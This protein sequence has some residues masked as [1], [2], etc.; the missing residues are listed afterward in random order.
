LRDLLLA[1]VL[2]VL[3]PMCFRRP[4]IGAMT[5]AW[6]SLMSPHR[7]AYGF[8][9]TAPVAMLVGGATLLGLL[10]SK[11]PKRLPMAAPVVWLALFTGWMLVTYPFSFEPMSVNYEQLDKVMKIMLMTFVVVAVIHTRKQVDI[12][13]AVVALSVGFYGIKGGVFA[14][15]T[16]G[17]FRVR[18]PV[19]FIAGNN[20]IG[21]ALVMTI[22]LLYYLLLQVQNANI[23]RVLWVSIFLTAVAAI[24]TQSR[25]ALLAILGMSAVMLLRS[26]QRLRLFP[27]MLLTAVFITVFMPDQWWDRMQTIGEYQEDQSAMGRINA[28]TLA[29][30]V[31]TSNFFGGGFLL[32][33]PETFSRYAPDPGFIAVAHSIYFQILG[34]HGFVGL[35]LFLAFWLSTW[36]T[37]RWVARNSP[38]PADKQ[39]ARLIEISLVGYAVGGAFLNLAYFDGPYYLMAALVIVRY[40]IL[41]NRRAAA[42]QG[43]PQAMQGSGAALGEQ[44]GSR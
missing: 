21:L 18:G 44:R 39:L 4:W 14:L 5:W 23:R 34:Q 33:T 36:N 16:G 8:M 26:P 22:P 10:F 3:V 25:G 9:Y 35:F 2:V 37:S 11:D 43:A 1:A 41:G 27:P 7:L 28:W 12:L 24:G 17:G 40:K 13:I 30:N 32:E 38:S 29:W 42:G 31:A 19:G 15:T 6:V 20:E